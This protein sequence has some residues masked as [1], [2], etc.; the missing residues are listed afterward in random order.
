MTDGIATASILFDIQFFH[1]LPVPSKFMQVIAFRRVTRRAMTPDYTP[2]LPKIFNV[3]QK[4]GVSG[5][6]AHVFEELVLDGYLSDASEILGA[7]RP[8]KVV[9]YI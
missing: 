1:L 2:F 3:V 8:E 5:F 6:G 7:A 4:K 9:R